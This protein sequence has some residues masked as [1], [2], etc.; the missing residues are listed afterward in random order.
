MGLSNPN[1]RRRRIKTARHGKGKRWQA[2]WEENGKTVTKTFLTEDA[3]EDFCSRVEVAQ[4]DGNWITKDKRSI[5]FADLYEP[6]ITTEEQK[7]LAKN[8]LAGYQSAWAH[9]EPAWGN[10]PIFDADV[11]VIMAWIPTLKTRRI[12]QD[13]GDATTIGNGTQRKIGL[14]I[15]G[16][17]DLA[18]TRKALK[19]NPMKKG[20]L[21]TQ[22]PGNRRAL[23]V[24]E[25]DALIDAAPTP[26]AELLTRT[27]LMTGL[28]PGE[29]K[30][31]KVS[32]LDYYRGRLTIR[33][34][35]DDLGCYGPTKNRRTR[36][37][38]VGGD[39]LLDLDDATDGRDDDDWL[40]PD[41]HGNVWTD[42]RWRRIWA[43]MCHAAGLENIDTYTLRHTAVSFAIASGADV[44]AIQRMC[45][46]AS[47]AT[48]LDIYGYL[49][50]EGLDAVPGAMESHMARERERERLQEQ[51]RAERRTQGRGRLRA[52]GS[53]D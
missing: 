19:T 6:W 32:D 27:M 5:T 26:S 8:T 9:I 42:A 21:V 48:T 43:A 10:T 38:P 39:L 13:A 3:A 41:E 12:G 29:A 7:G 37:V 11:E 53:D 4:A 52:V 30:G 40:L 34:A 25:V 20:D 33:G 24:T 46:H 36:D 51:R 44:Y 47:A 16:L 45:G 28:R 2:V 50:D 18:V 31:L 22:K 15:K 49:W 14:V 17:Y 23:T 1:V 35:V